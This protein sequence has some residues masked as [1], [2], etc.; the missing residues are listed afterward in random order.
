VDAPVGVADGDLL[1]LVA[2]LGNGSGAVYPTT[3][4]GWSLLTT[5]SASDVPG[6]TLTTSVYW[7]IAASEPSGYTVDYEDFSHASEATVAAY[8]GASTSAPA[9]TSA[10]GTGSTSTI[11]GLTAEADDTLFVYYGHNWTAAGGL[12]PPAGTTPTW[13]ER[14]DSS[15]ALSYLA[16]GALNSGEST[17]DDTQANTNGGNDAWT[18]VLVALAPALSAIAGDVA[19]SDS[20]ADTAELSG[21]VRVSGALAAQET[22]AD[23][24]ALTGILPATGLLAAIESGSDSAA[25]A[26][27]ILVAGLLSAQET[28]S[29]TARI[30]QA[31]PDFSDALTF[32]VSADD[33]TYAAAAQDL[34][35][36]VPADDLRYGVGAS[37]LRYTTPAR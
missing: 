35:Y 14:L 1:L 15:G 27:Q 32:E 12:T 16:D 6:F 9:A 3:P 29:D 4:S 20:G 28:G 5:A 11:S 17:G 19:A 21:G 8:R 2:L 23:S 7:R 36:T 31:L 26:G 25:L 24:A 13:T 10:S 34:R 37:D 30:L 33:L 22:G 18:A